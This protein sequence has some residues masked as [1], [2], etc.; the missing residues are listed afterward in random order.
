MSEKVCFLTLN[1]ISDS[2]ISHHRMGWVIPNIFF[3]AF[4]R[5][6]A[7]MF[8][9]LH[10]NSRA[11]F[12]NRDYNAERDLKKIIPKHVK[13][14]WARGKLS[15]LTRSCRFFPSFSF[16]V[17]LSCRYNSVPSLHRICRF[18]PRNSNRILCYANGW[19]CFS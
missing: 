6:S 17:L 16:S 13:W 18:A 10:S 19:H 5:H 11:L 3:L 2:K 9:I 8:V 15:C 14:L 12:G 4:Q 1:T 7:K